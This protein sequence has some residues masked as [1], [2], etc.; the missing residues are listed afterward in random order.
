MTV[1][2]RTLL[3]ELGFKG[4]GPVGG[5]ANA[6]SFD[7]GPFELTATR[8]VNRWLRDVWL[9]G[10]VANNG[11]SIAL[12]EFEMPLDVE[13]REQGTAWIAEHVAEWA[14]SPH[15]PQ[16]LHDGF[17][18]RDELP[19]R[20]T[21]LAFEG[22]PRC[23]VARD[24][25]RLPN[26][27]LRLAA[28]EAGPDLHANV[29]FDGEVLKITLPRGLVAVPAS[30]DAWPTPVT[31]RLASLRHL[32]QRLVDPSLEVAVHGGHLLVGRLRVPVV[33]DEAGPSVS[34]GVPNAGL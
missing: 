8:G 6:L 26:K 1:P 20:K 23:R 12:I 34:V 3:L 30:G 19:W 28:L 15:V 17:G 27:T 21:A 4:T 22:R 16:W 14:R 31:V 32:P 13:S 9:L 2:V 24:W 29:S 7:F 10:G 11:K 18:W 5:S 25:F 33:G